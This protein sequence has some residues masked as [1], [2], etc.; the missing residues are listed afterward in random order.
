VNPLFNPKL[1]IKR[2][3]LIYPPTT[4]AKLGRLNRDQQSIF[5]CSM[6]KEA[7]FFE[8]PDLHAGDEVI[9]TFW[10]TKEKMI[11][12]NIGYTDFVFQ[13]LGAKRERPQWKPPSPSTPSN[14][15]VVSLPGIAPEEI[16][17]IL[18]QDENHEV[19]ETFSAYFAAAVDSMELYR[20]KITT[21]IGEM[22]LGKIVNSEHQFAGILYP[23]VRMWANGDNLALLPWY[24]DAHVEFRKAVH[25]RIDSRTDTTL[26]ITGVD[27]A[28]E[29]DKQ[30]NL[31]WLGRLPNWTLDKP[32]Q[33]A[34][35]TFAPGAD[36]DGDYQMSADGQPGHWVAVDLETNLPIEAH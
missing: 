28:R 12:N 5:Y 10:K 3:D 32:F 36:A 9:L 19:R 15:E 18:S 20:Y 27:S 35:F 25:F 24:V 13:K 34:S 6:H 11:V 29:F 14:H 8:I 31:I 2:S 16:D 21:A 33:K 4:L 7:V 1:P 17:K 22:H 23:S 30:G 26:S